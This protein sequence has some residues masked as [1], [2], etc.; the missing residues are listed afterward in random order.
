VILQIKVGDLTG[1]AQASEAIANG[2]KPVPIKFMLRVKNALRIDSCK[3]KRS[4]EDSSD[5][6]SIKAAIAVED[7]DVNLADVNVA[8]TLDSQ[9]FTIPAGRF[10]AKKN[11]KFVC[12]NADVNETGLA[13]GVYDVNNCSFKLT[14]KQTSVTAQPGYRN[15][16]IKFAD[17]NESEIVYLP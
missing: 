7:T 10:I 16:G 8:V 3:V 9:T 11:N 4:E 2:R 14:I 15:L 17:F 5:K 6:L 13:T 12:K 1:T